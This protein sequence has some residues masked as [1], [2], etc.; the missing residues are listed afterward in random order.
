MPSSEPS[1]L[2]WSGCAWLKKMRSEPQ[3]ERMGSPTSSTTSSS[4]TWSDV[5]TP[6]TE[7]PRTV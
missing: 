2:A 4:G 5:Y 3:K 1:P 6:P 7:T